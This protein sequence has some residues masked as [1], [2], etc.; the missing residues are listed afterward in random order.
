MQM[1]FLTRI[2]VGRRDEMAEAA[3]Q[4]KIIMKKKRKKK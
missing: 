1:L 3:L 4:F 2:D